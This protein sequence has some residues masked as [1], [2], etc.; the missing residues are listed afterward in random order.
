MHFLVLGA[1]RSATALIAYLAGQLAALQATLT[2]ADADLALAQAKI[3]G[4]D[5]TGA[6]KAERFDINQAEASA[7]LVSQADIVISLLPASLHPLVAGHCLALGK[8]LLTA[9]YLSPE[10]EAMHAAAE[11]KGLLFLNECGLDPGLDHMS[12]MQVID[13]LKAEGAAITSFRSYCGGLV[14]PEWDTNPW[15]YK[16]SWNPRNVIVAGQG[17]TK[18]LEDGEYKYLPYHQLFARPHLVQ[19][20]FAGTFDSYP[21]RD[22]LAYRSRYGLEEI[23]TLIRGTLRRPGYCSAWHLLVTLGL[24]DDSYVVENSEQL[25]YGQFVEGYLPPAPEQGEWNRGSSSDYDGQRLEQRL[26]AYTYTDLNGREMSKL[27]WL[28]LFSPQVIGKAGLTPAQIVQQ[29][30]EQKWQLL[31]GDKDQVVMQHEFEYSLP[32]EGVASEEESLA[33]SARAAAARQRRLH[34]SLVVTGK[35]DVHTAMAQTVGLPLGI[36]A[37]LL[38]QGLIGQRGVAIPIAQEIYQPILAELAT[39]GITFRELQ[40]DPHAEA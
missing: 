24:T 36:A 12:A 37:K 13:R 15:G 30:A 31:P 28:G 22:S 26:A 4:L 18:Y 3:E 9:S 39:L 33:S 35:D 40:V 19:V 27:R 29:L 17:T 25:T 7:A 11:A 10:M 2:V 1:G 6:V 34:S 5:A 38:A 8:H 16:F 21:N 23:N 32:H 20:A 14:A